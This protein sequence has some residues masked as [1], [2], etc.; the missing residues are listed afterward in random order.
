MLLLLF[1]LCSVLVSV[2]VVV[3]CYCLSCYAVFLFRSMSGSY[4]LL[5]LFLLCSVFFL[6][7]WWLFVDVCVLAMQCSCFGQCR[8]VICC[9]CCSC[10]AVFFSVNVVVIC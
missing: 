10:Y 1:L 4:L 3:I 2:N 6:S 5:L 9:C 7:I 8:V